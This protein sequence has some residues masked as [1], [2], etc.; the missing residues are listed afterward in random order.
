MEVSTFVSIPPKE[1][2][3]FAEFPA[4]VPISGNEK[5]I[6]CLINTLTP[7]GESLASKTDLLGRS[8]PTC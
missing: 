8:G 5:W 4:G 6:S 1:L 7:F 2:I 3:E